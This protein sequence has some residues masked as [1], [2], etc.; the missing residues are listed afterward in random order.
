M[1]VQLQ[2]LQEQYGFPTAQGFVATSIPGVRF[3][4]ST[5]AVARTPLLYSAGIIII[6]Q[7]HKIGYLGDRVF[8]YD[9]QNYLILGAPLPFDC[10]TYATPEKPLLGIFLDIDL[11]LLHELVAIVMADSPTLKLEANAVPRGVEP[12][13]LD[14]A[15]RDATER[16]LRC[17]TSSLDSKAL[18]RSLVRELLYRVLR[19]CHG[20]S[21]YALTHHHGQYARVTKALNRIHQDYALPLTVEVLAQESQMSVSAFHRTFKQITADSPLQYLKKIR[22]NKAKSLIVSE[23]IQ[24]SVAASR[25]GY[26]SASQFSR[27]FKRYFKVLP[28]KAGQ[29]GYAQL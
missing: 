12:V 7:G 19:G 22:L 5:Q 4:W 28:S 13:K 6:R 16:L 14:D 15:M 18:G 9:E 20:Q 21:L 29:I 10:E 2:A 11:A 3:F 27:E 8:R 1:T 17:L 23:G 24:A 26:E 25:V